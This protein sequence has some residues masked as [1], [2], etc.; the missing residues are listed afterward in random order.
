MNSTFVRDDYFYTWQQFEPLEKASDGK[1]LIRGIVSSEAVDADGDIILQDGIDFSFFKSRGHITEE[2]PLGNTNIVGEPVDISPTVVRGVKATQID[3]VLYSHVPRAVELW[4]QSV[5]MKK[6]GA[7]RALGFSIEGKPLQ[8]SRANAVRGGRGA[9]RI[10]ERSWVHSS[11]I[12]PVPKNPLTFWQPQIAAAMKLLFGGGGGDFVSVDGA[13][14]SV[15]E[16][17]RAIVGEM[18]REGFV[19]ALVEQ[20]GQALTEFRAGAGAPPPGVA[21]VSAERAALIAGVPTEL[22]GLARFIHRLP[23]A[24]AMTIEEAKRQL[25]SVQRFNNVPVN[26][27]VPT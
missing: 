14:G 5:G 24:G 25:A 7:T 4:E 21:G 3:A 2:H 17:A 16:L 19:P 10:V 13:N 26:G 23:S 27:E 8:A 15:G 12:S 1:M 22:L 11:A 9:R 18:G 6:S 20:L